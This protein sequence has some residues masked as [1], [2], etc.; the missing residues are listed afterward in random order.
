M[1]ECYSYNKCMVNF[2]N[3]NVRYEGETDLEI[4]SVRVKQKSTY[5]I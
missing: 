1:I 3:K 2:T 5:I 4:Y